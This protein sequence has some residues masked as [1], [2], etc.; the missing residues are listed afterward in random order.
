MYGA[1]DCI[2]DSGFDFMI[3]YK[4]MIKKMSDAGY[5][6]SRIRREKL[7]G[8]TTLSRIRNG[9]SITMESLDSICKMTGLPVQELIEYVPDET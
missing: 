1:D 8:Q 2:Q 7:L 6:V 4:D 3:I 9:D 5:N